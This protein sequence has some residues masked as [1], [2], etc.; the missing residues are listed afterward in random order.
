MASQTTKEFRVRNGLDVI[1]NI[2]VTGTVDTVDIA[3]LKSDFDSHSHAFSEITSTPTTIAG[4]GITDF[5]TNSDTWLG[6][7][8]TDNLSEG[9][10]NLYYSSTLFDTDFSG[11]STDDL[12]EG[13][14]NLY[15]SSALFDTD[16]SSKNSDDLTEGTTNRYYT[17]TREAEVVGDILALSI[18]LG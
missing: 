8:T 9:S 16:F 2:T 5:D 12:T 17:T 1:G 13:S 4:Y 7:K 11:K 3:Q 15:Y 14:T 6:T 10:T 18:A